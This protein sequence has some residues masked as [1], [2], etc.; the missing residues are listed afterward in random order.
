MAH[1]L[2]QRWDSAWSSYDEAVGS[3]TGIVELRCDCA[4]DLLRAGEINDEVETFPA[5]ERVLIEPD[6]ALPLP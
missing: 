6:G 3:R 5:I 1:A 2:Q 4:F